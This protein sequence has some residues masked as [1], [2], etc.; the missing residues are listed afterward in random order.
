MLTLGL[1]SGAV[2]IAL[3]LGW[4]VLR[5]RTDLASM[6]SGRAGDEA[7]DTLAAWPPEAALVMNTI[8]RRAYQ[9]LVRALPPEYIVLAQVPLARF[10]R[11]PSR[12]SYR[13]WVRRVGRLIA[14][15]RVFDNGAQVLAVVNLRPAPGKES[16]R[17]RER[18]ERM[19]RVLRKAGIRVTIWTEDALPHPDRVRETVLGPTKPQ[20]LVTAPATPA[21]PPPKLAGMDDEQTEWRRADPVPSTFFD[22]LDSAPTPL[23]HPLRK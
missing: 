15:R 14:G 5:R 1:L 10:L 20:G 21:A 12:H 17:G 22:D 6:T 18:H 23:A 3:V 16:A 4:W 8:E 2:L 9:L 7:L 19:D 13:E 11:V